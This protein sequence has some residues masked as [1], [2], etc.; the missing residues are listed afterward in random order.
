MKND[1]GAAYPE[2]KKYTDCHGHEITALEGGMFLR[3][4]F[5]GTA[6]DGDVEFMKKVLDALKMISTPVACRY[7]HADAMI[8]E[9]LMP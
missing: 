7:A 2:Q 4:W 5:A 9:R 6:T 8:A 3:D 1:G